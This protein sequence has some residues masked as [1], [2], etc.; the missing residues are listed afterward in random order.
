MGSVRRH[1]GRSR[2]LLCAQ[3]SQVRVHLARAHLAADTS[4]NVDLSFEHRVR[5]TDL[6]FKLSPYYRGTMDQFENILLN[7]SGAESGINIGASVLMASSWP[8]RR[9]ISPATGWPDSSP[10]PTTTAVSATPSSPAE[11][12]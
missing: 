1:A 12:A 11:T 6:S 10:S 3:V 8:S 2:Q 4:H 5:G 9:A 7:A